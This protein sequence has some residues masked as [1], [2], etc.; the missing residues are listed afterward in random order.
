MTDFIPYADT[1]HLIL[2]LPEGLDNSFNAGKCCGYAEQ[3]DIFDVEFLLYIQQQ[4]S[5][6][7]TFVQP[8]MSYGVGWGNGAF[9]LTYALK[10]AP[11]LFKAIAPIAGYTEDIP[12]HTN[13]GIMMHHSLDDSMIRPSGCCKDASMPQCH[14]SITSDTCVSVL[15]VFDL[16]ARAVNL[17]GYDVPQSI[18]LIGG[19][20][21][22][23]SKGAT[24]SLSSHD[25]ATVL[26]LRVNSN[27]PSSMA[28]SQM[29]TT[30]ATSKIPLDV[31]YQD[32][33]VIC[34]T[35]S[36][37]HCVSNSTLCLYTDKG[38]FEYPDFASAFSMGG[39]V[40][41][42]F[43]NDACSLNNGV[44]EVFGN[45]GT[46]KKRVCACV[47]DNVEFGGVFCLDELNEDGTI[48]LKQSSAEGSTE[49]VPTEVPVIQAEIDAAPLSATDTSLSE[50]QPAT[51]DKSTNHG[52]IGALLLAV[53][54]VS[55]FAIRVQK[56]RRTW[57]RS[58]RDGDVFD[59][60]NMFGFG[61]RGVNPYHDYFKGRSNQ[62]TQSTT[63]L[64]HLPALG[65]NV[66]YEYDRRESENS[67]DSSDLKLLRSYRQK[68]QN[69]GG[70]GG[71]RGMRGPHERSD[72][73]EL[74]QC[75]RQR[76][77]ED[78]LQKQTSFR[79]EDEV[80]RQQTQVGNSRRNSHESNP[81]W[82]KPPQRGSFKVHIDE[83]E[84]E[85]LDLSFSTVYKDLDPDA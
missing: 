18:D 7:F 33:H 29:T 49:S 19:V 16:F 30:I 44:W 54:I 76:Q 45:E 50:A 53:T 78:N 22:G 5:E 81:F 84:A 32:S 63:E 37:A 4:L 61:E 82:D 31:S 75:Y 77:Q 55:C 57:Y 43:A 10:Q 69:E 39:E 27:D 9:L 68:M 72:D 15:E 36:S 67:L 48:A 74:L 70:V 12:S 59:D 21:V 79:K 73:L 25:D 8:E 41:H 58:S 6:E 26:E 65:A 2:V 38:H 24:Y 13:I 46:N 35:A 3:H 42:Y 14:R 85:G 83:E 28:S 34:Q 20:V 80:V 66:S 51:F 23:G 52:V 71:L 40:M 62:G 60:E 64:A 56:R 17:C 47:V 1:H 11:T